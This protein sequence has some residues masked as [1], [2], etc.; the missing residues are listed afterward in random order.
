[1]PQHTT[2]Q[3]ILIQTFG[4][5]LNAWP[6]FLKDFRFGALDLNFEIR[7]WTYGHRTE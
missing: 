4:P 6:N 3:R 7:F 1:M 5:N 2:R